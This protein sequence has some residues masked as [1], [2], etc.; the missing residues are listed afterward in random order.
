M[1]DGKPK[2]YTEIQITAA[3]G[4]KDSGNSYDLPL[5]DEISTP[6]EKVTETVEDGQTVLNALDGTIEVF[7]YNLDVLTD[8]NV[9]DEATIVNKAKI[10]LIGATGTDDLTMDDV[11]IHAHEDRQT[12]DRIGARVMA[13]KRATSDPMATS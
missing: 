10:W 1:A 13:T 9:Q 7:T 6:T 5:Q 11:R 4:A 3:G 8:S 2:I 12:T